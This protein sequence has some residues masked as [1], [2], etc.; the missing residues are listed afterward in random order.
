[1]SKESF[2]KSLIKG[3]K[4][5]SSEKRGIKKVGKKEQRKKAEKIEK[6][7]G[8]VEKLKKLWE[9]SEKEIKKME[10]DEV[11]SF[12]SSL[13]LPET[14][15]IF[16]EDISNK[17]LK[18]FDWKRFKER[19]FLGDDLGLFL[20]AFLE[21]NIKNHILSQKNEGIEFEKIKPVE[22]CLKV[23]EI[24]IILNFLGYQ[25]P[26]KLLL[27]IEGDCGLNTGE[28]MQG[29]KIIVEGDC[30]DGTGSEMQEGEINIKGNCR[31][32]TGY[33]IQGGRINVEGNCRDWTGNR[34]RGGRIIVK[35]D[36][37]NYTGGKMEGGVLDIKGEARFFDKSAFSSKNQGTI[38][39][40]G[41]IEIWKNGNWTKKGREM[42]KRKEFL[43][44]K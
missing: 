41:N 25:N 43:I 37:G 42:L 11:F 2:L 39:I 38:I 10:V 24:P 19:K 8:L 13:S 27:T 20:S 17:F 4:E 9:E 28:K 34:M 23:K 32:W 15:H 3:R 33:K 35:G 29:G 21:K 26:K 44:Q 36:C 1:M 40:R 6:I 7:E 5:K 12:I 16:L 18:E 14:S 30:N 31:N 22:V